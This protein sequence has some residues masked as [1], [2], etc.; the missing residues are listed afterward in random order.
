MR[1]IL[2]PI[3]ILSAARLSASAVYQ[4]SAPVTSVISSETDGHPRAFLWIPPACRQVRAVVVGQHNMEEEAIFENPAF[5]SAMDELGFA[6]VW[7]TPAWDLFFR[8][9]K[10]SDKAFDEM[11]AALA[12]VSGYTELASCPVVPLGHSAAASYPWN[13]AALRP[14]RTLA[15]VSVSGQWPYYKDQNTPDW[16]GRNVDGIPGLVSMGEY[17]AAESR[18]GTGLDQRR[19]HPLTALSM[20]ANPG[21]GHFESTDDKAAY[22]SLYLKQAARHRLPAVAGAPLKPIDPTR[23]GW[24]APRWRR[25][26]NPEAPAAPV[27]GYRGDPHQAFWYFDEALARATERFHEMHRGKKDQLTAFVQDGKIV[28]PDPKL[29]ERVRLRFQPLGD[30]VSFRVSGAFLDTAPAGSWLPEGTPVSHA[31]G[32]VTLLRNNGPV[33]RTGPDTWQ[34]QFDRVGTIN[35]KRSNAIFL[36]ATHPGDALHRPTVQQSVMRFPPANREGADQT[37][38][39]P[40]IPDQTAG[41][42]PLELKAT[43]SSGEPVRFYLREGPAELDGD[44]L[45]ITPIPPRARFP[46]QVTVVAWQ[47]GRA[48]EPRLK[49]AAPVER[50]I[51]IRR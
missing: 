48:I 13:F 26:E 18:A 34:I 28:A 41:G 31:P 6:I 27:A 35:R 19:R 32:P 16:G 40:E 39:F 15:V 45:R 51:S 46:I 1:A 5:R 11:M 8:F 33:I 44:T 2:L 50:T 29:H 20:I 37:I 25:N 17:E 10:G 30:G 42:P 3:L 9:D 21:G 49:S 7:V 24:L 4:W 23:D 47:Y 38:D 14:E 12:T 22:I 43:S 36:L